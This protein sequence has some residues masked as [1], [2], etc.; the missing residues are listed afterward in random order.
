M[1]KLVGE[2]FHRMRFSLKPEDAEYEWQHRALRGLRFANPLY[3]LCAAGG[4]RSRRRDLSVKP[5]EVVL[6]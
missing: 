5:I 2:F 3:E 4:L 6:Q 1:L